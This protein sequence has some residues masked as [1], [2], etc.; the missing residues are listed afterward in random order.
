MD[1]DILNSVAH[2]PFNLLVNLIIV[3]IFIYHIL[4]N[5][6]KSASL[7]FIKLKGYTILFY[8]QHL[9]AAMVRTKNMH[10]NI[11]IDMV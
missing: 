1:L 9:N 7:T 4:Y 11:I 6:F 10:D 2:L 8:S 5:S 3:S